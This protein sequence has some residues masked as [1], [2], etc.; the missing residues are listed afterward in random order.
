MAGKKMAISAEKF[1]E[2]RMKYAGQ[3]LEKDQLKEIFKNEIGFYLSNKW[4]SVLTDNKVLNPYKLG[5]KKA[6]IFSYSPIHK[7]RLHNM[8]TEVCKYMKE[9]NVKVIKEVPYIEVCDPIE[10][11]VKLLKEQGYKI[12]KPTTTFEEV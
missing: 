11:A 7:D 12:Y 2:V 10:E 1:N 3:K 5:K 9:H 6:Y 8:H 4:L